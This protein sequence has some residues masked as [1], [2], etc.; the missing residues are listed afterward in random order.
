MKTAYPGIRLTFSAMQFMSMKSSIF[1][2]QI[3]T[4]TLS[5]GIAPRRASSEQATS[6]AMKVITSAYEVVRMSDFHDRYL[7]GSLDS[8]VACE[9]PRPVLNPPNICRPLHFSG[10]KTAPVVSEVS[11]FFPF[12]S[13][14]IVRRSPNVGYLASIAVGR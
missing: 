3:V 5:V 1:L 2:P 11:S 14:F 6:L 7:A 10:E 12:F 9:D 13:G 4:S 8:T